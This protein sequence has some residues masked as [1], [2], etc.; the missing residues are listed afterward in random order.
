MIRRMLFAG[1]AVLLAAAVSYP[2]CAAEV[3]NLVLNPGFEQVENNFP[4]DW[5]TFSPKDKEN[6]SIDAAATAGSKYSLKVQGSSDVSWAPVF[7]NTINVTPGA[8]YTLG[9]YYKANVQKGEVIFALREMTEKQESIKFNHVN[10]PKQ[11]GWGFFSQKL[12]LGPTTKTVQVFIVLRQ[13]PGEA[14]FDDVILVKGDLPNAG[15]YAAKIK[16]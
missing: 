16:K 8:E 3:Q 1:V 11:T 15:E 10:V 12:A 7:S 14:W 9:A 2:V 5:R 6:Y 13:A 4:K